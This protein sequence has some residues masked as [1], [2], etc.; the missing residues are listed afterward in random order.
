MNH[1]LNIKPFWLYSVCVWFTSLHID[2]IHKFKFIPV[3]KVFVVV[4]VE[5]LVQGD[6]SKKNTSYDF[7]EK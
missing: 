3:I 4:L 2:K 7:V 6:S 1:K 5:L